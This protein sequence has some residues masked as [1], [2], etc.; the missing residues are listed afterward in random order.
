MK[1]IFE[2][3]FFQHI[4]F[5]FEPDHDFCRSVFWFLGSISYII[6][7]D[8][9]LFNSFLDNLFLILCQTLIWQIVLFLFKHIKYHFIN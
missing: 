4:L 9:I 5:I 3:I 1:W 7:N 6:K 8:Q 2:N